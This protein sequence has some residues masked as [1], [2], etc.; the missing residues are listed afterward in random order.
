MATLLSLFL[1]F[2]FV[3]P[4]P[5]AVAALRGCLGLE[6]TL[7]SPGAPGKSSQSLSLASLSLAESQAHPVL[8]PSLPEEL[9]S[10]GQVDPCLRLEVVH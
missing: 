6:Q 9:R 2:I 7:T 10:A 1:S 5:V 8:C 3:N 4:F